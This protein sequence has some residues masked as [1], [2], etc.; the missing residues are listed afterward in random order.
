MNINSIKE[1][2]D[3]FGVT[4]ILMN[5]LMLVTILKIKFWWQK[6]VGDMPIGHQHYYMLNCDVGDRFVMLEA[7]NAS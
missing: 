3:Q 4:V 6:G 2:D 1:I 5:E 7:K